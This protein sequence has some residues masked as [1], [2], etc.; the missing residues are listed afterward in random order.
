LK[1]VTPVKSGN[2]TIYKVGP[3]TYIPENVIPK[4]AL[5]EF[6]SCKTVVS[7]KNP[8]I[9]VNGDLF[10]PIKNKTIQPVKI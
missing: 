4:E 6:E 10:V 9:S 8:V 1:P 2:I 7:P 5:K 3:I